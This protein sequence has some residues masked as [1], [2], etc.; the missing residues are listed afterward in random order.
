V[1]WEGVVVM[2]NPYEVLEI[3]QG[4]SPEEVKQAYRELVKKYHPD[5]YND[6]P[7][8]DLAEEKMREINEAYESLTSQSYQGDSGYRGNEGYS[9]RSYDNGS[10]EAQAFARIRDHI[11]RNNLRAA[12]DELNRSNTKNA[13]W[14]YLRGMISMRKGWYSQAYEDLQRAV[15]MDPSNYEYREAYNRV[16]NSNRSYQNNSYRSRGSSN[17]MCDTLTCLCCSDQCCECMGGDLISC[18]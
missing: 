9:D 8:K 7:L 3:K 17:D 16:L 12:E 4:A 18:C 1:S 10:N 2:R 11:N 14:Y 13:E 6:N 15:N 5:K